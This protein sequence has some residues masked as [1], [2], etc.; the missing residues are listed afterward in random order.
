M[1]SVTR[2]W[3]W[4]LGLVATA[5]V[6]GCASSDAPQ[7]GTP[8][9]PRPAQVAPT[10]QEPT[11]FDEV[12][13]VGQLPSRVWP[14][15]KYYRNALAL[16]QNAERIGFFNQTSDYK[17][18]LYLREIGADARVD[19]RVLVRPGM[20][21]DDVRARFSNE[22]W[23]REPI[24][25]GESEVYSIKRFNGRGYTRMLITLLDGRVEGYQA[26]SEQ[27]WARDDT[28]LSECVR[29][30]QD[31]ARFLERGMP[32]STLRMLIEEWP[33][34]QAQIYLTLADTTLYRSSR[35]TPTSTMRREE[36][37]SRL[38]AM[39]TLARR[40]HPDAERNELNHYRYALLEPDLVRNEANR[41]FWRYNIRFGD[42]TIHLFL[43]WQEA[44]LVEWYAEPQPE[45]VDVR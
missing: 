28:I 38:A 11:N 39:R 29:I 41:V 7:E 25:Y 27:Q 20:S 33:V 10:L 40:L 6:A 43:V 36:F 34:R 44:E 14:R 13:P 15:E 12:I 16:L 3:I 23:E 42:R 1:T 18:D 37:E 35:E 32:Q 2:I 8:D 26:Y 9:A 22:M 19:L 30:E 21:L 5:S 17:R 24:R 4:G 31:V 45:T